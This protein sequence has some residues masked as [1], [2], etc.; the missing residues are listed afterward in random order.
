MDQEIVDVSQKENFSTRQAPLPRGERPGVFT[1]VG[2]QPHRPRWSP[3]GHCRSGRSPGT[4][5]PPVTASW[6]STAKPDGLAA[7]AGAVDPNDKA[8]IH[9]RTGPKL[10]C[11]PRRKVGQGAIQPDAGGVFELPLGRPGCPDRQAAPAALPWQ[12]RTLR[13]A[14]IAARPDGLIHWGTT[15]ENAGHQTGRVG[16]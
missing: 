7:V 5:S 15:W 14:E 12:A 8:E 9:Q 3:P 13:G 6:S 10:T 11:Q 1:G 4:R 2:L 16:R